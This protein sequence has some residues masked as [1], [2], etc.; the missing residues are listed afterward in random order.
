MA[1]VVKQYF[2]EDRAL[3]TETP[4]NN[5]RNFGIGKKLANLHALRSVGF[6]VNRRLPHVETLSQDCRIGVTCLF[7]G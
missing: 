3:R 5:T 7:F 2:K 1:I 4:I 6:T